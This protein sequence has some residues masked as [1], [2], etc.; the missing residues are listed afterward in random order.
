MKNLVYQYKQVAFINSILVFVL[1]AFI[2]VV[3]Q[4]DLVFLI[5][6]FPGKQISNPVT[7]FCFLLTAMSFV[8]LTY[9]N[10][11]FQRV[12]RVIGL[13]VLVVALLRFIE[14]IFSF[15]T[16]ADKWLY[17]EKL[18]IYGNG[19]FPNYMAPNTTVIFFVLGLSLV[20]YPASNRRN[21]ISEY[22]SLGILLVS[23]LLLVAYLYNAVEVYRVRSFVPIDFPSVLSFFL[24]SS[25]LLLDKSDIGIFKVFTTKYAGGKTIRFLLPFITVVPVATGLLQMAGQDEGLYSSHFGATMFVIANI[26]IAG[27]IIWWYSHTLNESSM[28]LAQ[29]MEQRKILEEQLLQLNRLL[30]NKVV[31]STS[32]LSLV[33]DEKRMLE[34]KL[35]GDKINE[36]KKLMQATI[37]GQEKEKKQIGM[38]LHDHINQVL[39]SSR[40]YMQIAKTDEKIRVDM[41]DKS[42]DQLTSAINDIR[43]LSKSLVPHT[44]ESGGILEGVKELT[45]IFQLSTDLKFTTQLS[46]QATEKL[47]NQQQIA[48]FRIVQEQLNNI[49]KH[50]DAKNVFIRLD[51]EDGHVSLFVEDDGKGFDVNSKP[52]G[53]GLSNIRSRTEMLGGEMQ[54]D[55]AQNKGCRLRVTI[56]LQL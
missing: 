20:L 55:S 52:E 33:T 13:A 35:L 26:I 24:L 36:Q 1:S 15:R 18:S 25:S 54:I 29:E 5:N 2:I 53:I 34:Q 16:D 8:C 51:G 6:L 39:A 14:I 41:I 10:R 22:L 56:P 11:G 46:S 48:L 23:L 27:C 47:D 4:F 3:W 17:P 21:F 43:N 49:I 37:E 28:V 32:Q 9:D 30:E 45:E 42:I 31:E 44:I 40:L 38:E 7:A 12:G 50:A 19:G